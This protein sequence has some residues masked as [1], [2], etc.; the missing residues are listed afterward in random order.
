MGF[1]IY[2]AVTGF[3]SDLEGQIIEACGSRFVAA[4]E[5]LEGHGR[6]GDEDWVS[7]FSAVG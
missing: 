1:V 3:T 6:I 7:V 4:D 5:F 2:R